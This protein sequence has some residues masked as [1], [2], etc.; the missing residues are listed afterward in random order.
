VQL[1][2]WHVPLEAPAGMEHAYPVQ[3]SAVEVHTEPCGWQADGAWH[4]PE[5]TPPSVPRQRCEQQSVP[6]VHAV[7]FAWQTPASE[8]VPASCEPPSGVPAS[9]GDGVTWQA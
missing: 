6:K 5:P 3:Q 9:L 1:L 8:P 2:V 4:V 7:P